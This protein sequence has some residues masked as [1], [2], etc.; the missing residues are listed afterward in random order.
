MVMVSYFLFSSLLSLFSPFLSSLL[1]LVSCLFSRL[2]SLVSRLSSLFSLL[3]SLFSLSLTLLSV[4]SNTLLLLS[5]TLPSVSFLPSGWIPRQRRVPARTPRCTRLGRRAAA[6]RAVCCRVGN[7]D[8]CRLALA[9]L[10]GRSAR[11]R[12]LRARRTA[13]WRR[14]RRARASVRSSSAP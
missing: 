11:P 8:C 4:T 14:I 5:H 1:S 12:D 13:T 9:R 10:R 2:S 7:A 6:L 3:S